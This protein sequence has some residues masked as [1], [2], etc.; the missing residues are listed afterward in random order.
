[1]TSREAFV[2]GWMYGRIE[3]RLPDYDKSGFKFRQA[4]EY[5]LAGFGAI[6]AEAMRRGVLTDQ[7]VEEI[8]AAAQEIDSVEDDGIQ[9]M[10]YQGAWQLA[11]YKGK[12]GQPLPQ[13]G[14]D[15]KAARIAKRIPQAQLAELMGVDQPVIS[16]WENGTVKPSAANMAKLREILK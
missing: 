9:P 5:P 10:Q 8:M 16:R 6:H 1:M 11:Y 14:I 13:E 15:I 2:F 3:R 12:S 7:D 4:S